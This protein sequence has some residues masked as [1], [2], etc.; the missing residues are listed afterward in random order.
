M[1]AALVGIILFCLEIGWEAS[2][3]SPHVV[4]VGTFVTVLEM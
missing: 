1:E 3:P 4:A 2:F